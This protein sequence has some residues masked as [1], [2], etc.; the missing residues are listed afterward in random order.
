MKNQI[1][2]N[3]GLT[4][5]A[6]VAARAEATAKIETAKAARV[7]ARAERGMTGHFDLSMVRPPR[8][9]DKEVVKKWPK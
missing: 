6:A 5:T 2:L 3:K 9:T 1:L 8:A 7:A 4:P